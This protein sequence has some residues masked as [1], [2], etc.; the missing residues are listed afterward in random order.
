[1]EAATHHVYL[2]V[3][4]LGLCKELT[5]GHPLDFSLGDIAKEVWHWPDFPCPAPWLH[6]PLP[7]ACE[8]SEYAFWRCSFL[9]EG[10]SEVAKTAA[11]HQRNPGSIFAAK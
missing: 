4:H 9:C 7:L 11:L 10:S 2:T 8:H 5:A 3:G 1:M 6:L